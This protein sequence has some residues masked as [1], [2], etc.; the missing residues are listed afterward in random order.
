MTG[1]DEVLARGDVRSVFQPIVELGSGAVIAYEALARGPHG[2]PLEAPD[3]LFAAARDV[4]RLRELDE[5]CRRVALRTAIGA[6]VLAPLMLFV[7]VEPE[8]LGTAPLEE[9]LEIAAG[10]PA[11]LQ[12]VLEITER[13]LAARPAELLAT[14]RRLREAG[15][16]VA[17]DDV[18][19]E[20]L[21]LAFMPLLRP[22]IVKLDLRLVQQRPGPAVAEI[23]NAVNAYAER[24]GAVLLAEGIED[25]EHLA[26]ARALGATL[27]Q[28][29][30]FGRPSPGLSTA[31]PVRA[32]ELR[33]P[34]PTAS[35]ATPFD[36]LPEGTTLRRSA[37]PLLIEISKH[38]EREAVR[39]G[40]TAVVVS[41]FQEAAQFTPRTRHRYRELAERVGFVSAIGAGLPVEPVRG[42]RG[43]DLAPGDP[44]RDEWDIAVLSPHFSAALLAR[45]LG[46]AGPDRQRRFEFALT[47]DRDTVADAAQ[48]LM[49][50]VLPAG[51][52]SS[53]PLVG[54]G[55]WGDQGDL[56]DQ[57][58]L[59]ATGAA[60]AGAGDGRGS[61]T[62]PDAGSALAGR[63][64]P[65]RH[66]R[67]PVATEAERTLRRALAATANGVSICDM[68]RPDQP[69]VYVNTAFERLS[70][71]RAEDVLGR[72]CRF[73]QGE[74]TDPA[75]VT[76]LREA[77]AEG[78]EARETLLNHRGP[79]RTPWW[80]EVYLAP[81][82][83]DEGRVVQ[84]IGVQNDVTGRVEAEA[85][86]QAERER[87][88]ALLVEAER[89]AGRDPLTD[90][91]HRHRLEER[92]EAVLLEASVTGT[93]TAVLHLDLDG[94]RAVNDDLGH[95]A[96]D[97]LLRAV[98]DR[99]RTRLRRGDL[100]ARLG[101]DEFLVVL[102]ALG[103]GTA[104][105]EGRRVADELA[106]L[107]ST[108]VTTSRG[109]VAVGVSVGVSTSPEDGDGFD[110]LLQAADVRMH[111][112]R[113]ARR[114]VLR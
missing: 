67:A 8:V 45:D 114:G 62:A 30:L 74:G 49:S 105:D 104:G 106:L 28:G 20:D 96:G 83:D 26:T 7:N 78:R 21:S 72:N 103:R 80:N 113:A 22:D 88:Q 95:A 32:L 68:T 5:L 64:A 52:R 25:E 50:R 34:R 69:L 75:A 36:C 86:L 43:A 99:L 4:D 46:D 3:A 48:A 79:Q 102:P 23:M 14:V 10:A 53:A 70:G 82:F 18:G 109:V 87:A 85:R 51:T 101:G 94:F 37:K 54:P 77:V 66:G 107:L 24:T 12:V 92:L 41:T 111:A 89:L 56:S 91:L 71:L 93:G 19:A 9:L 16:R 11:G 27:G 110:A 63:P 57:A 108:P 84:Y 60:A 29:W 15:W 59:G 35:S 112:D 17:L 73:L 58:D 76:R 90:L 81:V 6:G 13:A 39:L 61:S 42:V 1:I 44:L 40:G 38:L 65:G 55:A 97:E 98:A 47:Y 2:S 31:L 100:V 33:A